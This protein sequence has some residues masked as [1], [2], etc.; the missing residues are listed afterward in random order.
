[1]KIK[2]FFFK[3]CQKSTN[4]AHSAFAPFPPPVLPRCHKL[5]NE[6]LHYFTPLS[7]FTLL[8]FVLKCPIH[9]CSPSLPYSR[10]S[11]FSP[12]SQMNTSAQADDESPQLSFSCRTAP[13]GEHARKVGLERMENSSKSFCFSDRRHLCVCTAIAEKGSLI[14]RGC[15]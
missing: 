3:D 13:V 8:C 15:F 10:C 12:T 14:G 1:M 11:P 6:H 4:P 2:N 5:P 9:S 7:Y